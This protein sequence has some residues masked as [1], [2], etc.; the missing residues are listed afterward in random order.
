MH[1]PHAADSSTSWLPEGMGAAF[2]MG[3]LERWGVHKPGLEGKS[4]TTIP[5]VGLLGSL[6]TQS[7]GEPLCDPL[8]R[9]RQSRSEGCWWAVGGIPP[10]VPTF[11]SSQACLH[12]TAWRRKADSRVPDFRGSW[13][14]REEGGWS[15]RQGQDG[16]LSPSL[17]STST[18]HLPCPQNLWCFG[19]STIC[20]FWSVHLGELIPSV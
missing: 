15:P 18:W 9:L 4:P 8:A 13:G 1:S 3:S 19:D 10:L 20:T 7:S 16:E 12:Y 14:T 2:C 11:L 17:V 5:S 6:W